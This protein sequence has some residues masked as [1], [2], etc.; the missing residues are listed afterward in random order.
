[1]SNLPSRYSINALLATGAQPFGDEEEPLG[2]IGRNELPVPVAI[3]RDGILLDGHRRLKQM[4]REKR[5]YI[6]AGDV[7]VVKAATAETALEWAVKLNLQRR[8]VSTEQ[9]AALARKLQR[10]RGWSQAKIAD[11]FGVTRPAVSQWLGKHEGV[12]AETVVGLDHK[13]YPVK[14]KTKEKV[15]PHAWDP[16]RGYIVRDITKLTRR[17]EAAEVDGLTEEEIEVVKV[18]VQ[19]LMLMLDRALEDLGGEAF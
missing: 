13:V 15:I 16:E 9:K 8:Q 17:I 10:D 12:E 1:M 11:L 2:K 19:D 18:K 14:K 3:S 7:R 4:R 5:K 6:A